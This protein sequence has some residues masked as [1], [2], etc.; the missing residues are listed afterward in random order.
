MGLYSEKERPNPDRS[1]RTPAGLR[2]PSRNEIIIVVALRGQRERVLEVKLNR[3]ASELEAVTG[4]HPRVVQKTCSGSAVFG[5]ASWIAPDDLVRLLRAR[6]EQECPNGG[7]FHFSE[8][9]G[10]AWDS[11]IAVRATSVARM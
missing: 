2:A 7:M 9:A 6:L 11:V 1:G 3:I 10:E 4:F 8:E 5:T